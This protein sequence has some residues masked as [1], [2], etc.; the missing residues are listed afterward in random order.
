M[1]TTPYAEKNIFIF[2]SPLG[3]GDIVMAAYTKSE[4]RA[5]FKR[6]LGIGPKDRLPVAAEIEKLTERST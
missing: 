5:L 6:K 3:E 4:A 2:Y 1:R